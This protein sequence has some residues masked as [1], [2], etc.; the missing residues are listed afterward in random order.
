MAFFKPIFRPGGL[1]II[2]A[3]CLAVGN[4]VKAQVPARPTNFPNIN[5]PRHVS[6]EEAIA[7]LGD[8]LP[9]VAVFYRQTPE[10]LRDLL[11]RDKSLRKN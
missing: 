4:S 10:E 6:G 9:D 7:A 8:K 3:L 1:I 2:S 5:L 11:R